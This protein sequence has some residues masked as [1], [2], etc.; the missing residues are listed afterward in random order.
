ME[1]GQIVLLAL[2]I[3]CLACRHVQSDYQLST[4]KP[5]TFSTSKGSLWS[6]LLC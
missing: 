3:S 1:E 5:N 6:M 4:G 2:G